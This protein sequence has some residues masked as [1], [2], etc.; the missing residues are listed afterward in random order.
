[1]KV[2]SSWELRSLNDCLYQHMLSNSDNVF[3]IKI[4]PDINKCQWSGFFSNKGIEINT[5]ELSNELYCCDG[6]KYG[7]K[8]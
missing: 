7:S 6:R 3:K 8:K 2:M 4:G 5:L 1:M